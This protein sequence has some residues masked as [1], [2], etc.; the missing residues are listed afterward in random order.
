MASNRAGTDPVL[1]RLDAI[2]AVLK[3][4]M[5]LEGAKAGLKREDLRKIVA[6][7]NNRISRFMKHVRRSEKPSA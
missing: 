1:Q 5:I 2:L 3:D 6:V 7:D 4:L